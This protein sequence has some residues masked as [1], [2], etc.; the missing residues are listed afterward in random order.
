M[1][2]LSLLMLSLLVFSSVVFAQQGDVVSYNDFFSF[3]F[4]SIGEMKGASTL[5]IVVLASQILLKF[6]QSQFGELLGKYKLLFI[7]L[8]TMVGSVVG[9]MVSSNM[10]FLPALLS[11]ASLSALQ[12]F[13][14]QLYKQFIEKK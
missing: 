9:L 10:E 12:V 3:L 13:G 1:K 4:S 11:G 6:G 5:A 14:H 8:F 2:L 7:S